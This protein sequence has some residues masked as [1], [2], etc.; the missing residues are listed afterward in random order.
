MFEIFVRQQ[1]I[2]NAVFKQLNLV[3]SC[4]EFVTSMSKTKALELEK[5]EVI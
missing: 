2:K 4:E 5:M 3:P 1:T